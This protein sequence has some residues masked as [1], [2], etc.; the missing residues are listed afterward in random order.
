[1][2]NGK[3]TETK[4][5]GGALGVAA[6][7]L[8]NGCE[9]TSCTDAGCG[10]PL[11]LELKAEHWVA[12]EY[13]VAFTES[14]R[15]FECAFERGT[16]G[17][18]GQASEGEDQ[19]GD[20]V[21]CDQTAGDPANLSETPEV[22]SD[23]RGDITIVIKNAAERVPVSV[24][25][26]GALVLGEEVTPSYTKSHPN[27]PECGPTCLTAFETLTLPEDGA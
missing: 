2:L 8:I 27:G 6:A 13:V 10:Y 24:R 9:S 18:G 11:N 20:V 12:G 14:G 17:A 22:S 4:K 5:L 16:S 15:S 25:R 19:P 7:L 23:G 21:R 3:L 1:M 26:D